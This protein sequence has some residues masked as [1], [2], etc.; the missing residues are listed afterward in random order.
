[1]SGILCN[2]ANPTFGNTGEPNCSVEQKALAFPVIMPRFGS[3]GQRNTINVASGTLGA[4][5]TAKLN[6]ADP[7][8]RIYPLPRVENATFPRT[9][10]QYEEAESGRKYRLDGVGGVRTWNMELWGK[11]AVAAMHR[12]LKKYGCVELDVFWVDIA[13]S[14]FGI[15]DNPT[16]T[17][18]KGYEVS[19]E[20]F[21]IFKDYATNTTVQKLM[22]SW[23]LD[24][25]VCEENAYGITAGELGY[26][27]T[28]L[29][30]LQT[31]NQ[32]LTEPA[33]GTVNQVVKTTYGTAVTLQG[34]IGLDTS[35]AVL[36]LYNVTQDA[37]M[38]APTG[39]AP[40]VGS[41]GGYSFAYL[42]AEAALNDV[43]RV[44]VSGAPGYDVQDNTFEH[45]Y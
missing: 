40:I 22:I 17:V 35:G 19:S 32:T 8:D 18:M 20:T 45:A 29:S 16:D 41:D 6:A 9:D 31:A 25:Q 12:E 33:D 3:N 37:A 11:S 39:W 14:M 4:D 26:K 1:M 10:T 30:G 34:V 42:T 24:S 28:T 23:D 2:C 13:G 21:D 44:S 38:T 36:S 7:R 5:I 43:I 15:K 27:A